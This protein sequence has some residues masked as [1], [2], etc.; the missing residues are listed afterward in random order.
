M[1]VGEAD[2]LSE[3]PVVSWGLGAVIETPV[4]VGELTGTRVSLTA[5]LCTR[6]PLSVPFAKRVSVPATVPAWN[7]TVAP[8]VGTREPSVFVAFQV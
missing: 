8:V 2:R 1:Q 5:A 7:V 6:T 3:P 4:S